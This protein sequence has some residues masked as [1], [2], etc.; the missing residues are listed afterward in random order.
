MPQVQPTTVYD[1]V[2]HDTGWEHVY[3]IA[4]FGK[5][6]EQW[7]SEWS[8]SFV[9]VSDL[10]EQCGHLAYMQHFLN[11]VGFLHGYGSVSWVEY[12]WKRIE[13]LDRDGKHIAH[14]DVKLID[15]GT[16]TTKQGKT[17]TMEAE[18]YGY[19]QIDE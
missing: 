15:A 14:A 9:P 13:I 2:I 18:W 19:D 3:R 17:E 6:S 1:A 12:C 8:K 4:I 16:P 11:G 7:L 10:R 5:L